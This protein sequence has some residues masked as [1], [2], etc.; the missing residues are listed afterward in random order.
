[1]K[2]SARYLLCAVSIV[3]GVTF[4]H[5]Q[6]STP[7]FRRHR[8][9]ALPGQYIVVLHDSVTEHATA[10]AAS[11]LVARHGGVRRHVYTKA[12]KGF[13]A[14]I[15]EQQ[16]RSL[17]ADPRVAYVEEDGIARG[18][19]VQTLE[20]YVDGA[21]DRVDQRLRPLDG[22]YMYD[23]EGTGVHVYVIDSGIRNTHVEFGGRAFGT[24]SFVEEDGFGTSDCS[25]HG[26]G[27]ASVVAGARPGVA[28]QALLYSVRV[29]PCSNSTP[30]SVVIAGVDWVTANHQ[31]P[32]VANIS[33][34]G[35][36]SMAFNA[37][38]RG[39]I[40]AGVTVVGS[41]GND[42]TQACGMSPGG[43][44]EAVIVANADRDDRRHST[45]NYA[46]CVD[47]FAPGTDVLTAWASDDRAIALQTGT[48]FA[49]PFVTG[50]AALYLE[51]Y[52][53][54]SP[55]QVERAIID[56]ATPGVLGDQVLGANLPYAT[57]N[58]LL[59][60]PPLG[61]RTP[62]D[63]TLS[64]PASGETVS[65][66]ISMVA[67]A[68]DN[69]ELH[70]VRFYVNSALVGTVTDAPFSVS[71]DTRAFVNGL[72]S[73]R[74]EAEDVGGN[75][76]TT[77]TRNITVTNTTSPGPGKNLVVNGSFESGDTR[78]WFSDRAMTLNLDENLQQRTGV[79]NAACWH[80]TENS[81][82]CSIVQDVSVPEAGTYR[83]TIY[84]K[85]DRRGAWVGANLIS[86]SFETQPFVTPVE[87]RSAYWGP[88]ALYP[89]F[90]YEATVSAQ[91]GDTIKVW[92]YSPNLPGWLVVDDVSI[93]KQ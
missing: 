63:V 53:T 76:A 62:P 73:I 85:A 30:W 68:S 28:K 40:E 17:S 42:Q 67:N 8:G 79:Y 66:T 59:F 46:E 81:G 9:E 36:E 84:A 25:G 27:V 56:S 77:E 92:A 41:A 5:A 3:G 45:S 80:S 47:L 4:L 2:R 65:G 48:S 20:P 90:K 54:A 93:V 57:P 55:A 29:L 1:M 75:L 72:H 70:L 21:L 7:K 64:A 11:E 24:V 6:G 74:A 89:Y 61:D 86:Q 69:I 12:L 18:A 13:S 87:S 83:V 58:L 88:D 16:A 50:A 71:W 33:L 31:K 78:S 91:A 82:D 43:I 44:R 22:R 32:A 52:P 39:A 60:A 49:A 26:T 34:G 23:G 14:R 37:A 35:A 10:A 19:A 38:V 51:R 15:T